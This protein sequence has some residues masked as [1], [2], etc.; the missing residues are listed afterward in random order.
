MGAWIGHWPVPFLRA[1]PLVACVQGWWVPSSSPCAA[2]DTVLF[3]PSA[4]DHFPY[5]L[6]YPRAG[7]TAR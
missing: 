1:A 6:P 5:V 3:S 7:G 2:C 4:P